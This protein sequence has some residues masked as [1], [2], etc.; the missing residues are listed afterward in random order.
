MEEV[1]DIKNWF[2]PY[3]D[4]HLDAFKEVNRTGMWPEGFVPNDMHFSSFWRLELLEILAKAWLDHR[5]NLDDH[6]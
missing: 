4:E 5:E 6:K 1:R 3:S 2:D